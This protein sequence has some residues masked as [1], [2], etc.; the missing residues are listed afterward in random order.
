MKK[1]YLVLDA[2]REG[3]TPRQLGDTMTVGDLKELLDYYDD[4]TPII[5]SHDNGYTYGRVTELRFDLE[6]HP[7]D[8]EDEED[9]E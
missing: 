3:Y 9:D 4:D 1:E 5:L 8:D 7:D 6:D 2:R